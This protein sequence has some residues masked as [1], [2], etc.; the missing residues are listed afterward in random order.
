MAPIR[1]QKMFDKGVF[2]SRLNRFMV[3][4]EVRA[5]YEQ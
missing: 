2:L 5:K 1:L 4:V 3:G